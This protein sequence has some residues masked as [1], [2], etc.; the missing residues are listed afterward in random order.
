M[1]QV[2]ASVQINASPQAVFD[3][4]MDPSRLKDWV[5]IHRSVQSDGREPHQGATMDQVLVIR[6]V[7]FTVHWTLGSVTNPHEA[8]WEGRGPAGSRAR[9]RYR[10]DGPDEGPT[11]FEYTNEFSTPGGP[12]GRRA[13]QLVVGG[14]SEREAQRSLAKLKALLEG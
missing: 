2:T 1:T 9:I 13:S 12:L 3:T 6:G 7:G 4:V 8:Q 5:T 11:T 10:I 14:V